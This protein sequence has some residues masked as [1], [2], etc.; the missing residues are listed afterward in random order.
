MGNRNTHNIEISAEKLYKLAQGSNR[1]SAK[2]QG[3]YDGRFT[4]KV[5]PAKKR[6]EYLR[7]RRDK[8]GL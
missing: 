4:P 2:T 1:E 6:T 8:P 5:E 7:L 3:F